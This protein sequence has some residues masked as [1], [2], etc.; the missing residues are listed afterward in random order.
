MSPLKPIEFYSWYFSDAEFRKTF[1]TDDG[2]KSMWSAW[3]EDAKKADLSYGEAIIIM[4]TLGG[5]IE[6]R[7][8]KDY[9]GLKSV[10]TA[11]VY[12]KNEDFFKVTFEQGG[13]PRGEIR[14][15]TR[16][17]ARQLGCTW[18]AR[19]YSDTLTCFFRA[20]DR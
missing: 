10:R 9:L 15:T 2:E 14:C 17:A 11:T 4:D 8:L 1:D 19:A 7:N 12:P 16:S 18:T 20:E 3:A 6:I 13:E 5:K